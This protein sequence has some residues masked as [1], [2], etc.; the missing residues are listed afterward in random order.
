MVLA[1]AA[2][3][4]FIGWLLQDPSKNILNA[5][6]YAWSAIVLSFFQPSFL[7]SGWHIL[8]LVTLM[9]GG[10]IPAILFAGFLYGLLSRFFR[11]SDN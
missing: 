11:L 8:G 2:A 1:P 10:S 7:K 4:L 9:L 6:P 5:V 3:W